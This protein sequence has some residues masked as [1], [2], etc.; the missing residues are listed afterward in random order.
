MLYLLLLIPEIILIIAISLPTA[1]FAPIPVALTV[2]AALLLAAIFL[3]PAKRLYLY[4]RK[5]SRTVVRRFRARAVPQGLTFRPNDR[6][7]PAEVFRL[8]EIVGAVP[9][10]RLAT[11]DFTATLL[12]LNRRGVLALRVTESDDITRAEGIRVIVRRDL[13]TK[14]LAPH[15]Q[16]LLRLLNR[17]S[18]PASSIRL[19]ALADYVTRAPGRAQKYTDAFR[20]AV[21]RALIKKRI[22]G[23]VRDNKSS[24]PRIL[25][26]RLRV[27]TP[28]GEQCAAM[29]MAYLQS[30][31]TKPFLDTYQPRQSEDQQPF[32]DEA[33]RL[34]IDAAAAGCCARAAAA[35]MEEYLFTPE[36]L[37]PEHRFFSSLTETRIAFAAS[38]TGEGYFFLP[39]RS[40]ESAIRT[41]VLHGTAEERFIGFED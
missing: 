34:L 6:L 37:W 36:N 8:T 16:Q 4:I 29:R 9:H 39:L 22:I 5:K 41:A 40:F 23:S 26:P 17:A 2:I 24:L 30:I 21:D 1:I 10:D 32:A 27:L 28:R 11:A 20:R 12:D 14:T 13:D 35:L 3:R 15:E 31:C 18:G 7:T 25:R 19:S 33:E 38:P